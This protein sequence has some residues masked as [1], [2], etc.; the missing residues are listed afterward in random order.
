MYDPSNGGEK[1]AACPPLV[2]EKSNASLESSD[3]RRL[4][5]FDVAS[6]ISCATSTES[7]KNAC[8]AATEAFGCDYYLFGGYYPIVESIVVSSSF[9]YE[10]RAKYNAGGYIAIDPTVKHC[11][12]NTSPIIWQNIEYPEG[13]AGE[14]ERVLM[15]E[16]FEF[17][18]RSGISIPMHGSGAEGCMLSLVSRKENADFEYHDHAGL[19]VIAHAM[20]EATKRI[21]AKAGASPTAESLTPRE[22]ECLSW[23]AKG[24]T[25]WATSRILDV[26]ENTVIFHLRNAIKKL[27][28]TNRSHAVAKAAAHSK[29]T[30][31]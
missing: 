17:G 5:Y 4:L 29:I 9:P 24:K 23:T 7:L 19:Q 13:K 30:P 20:H 3:A 10:W 16:A 6:D 28:V 21:I 27:E 8:N 25:S 31:F 15:G 26:S 1:K 12:A 11:W 2:A 22:I 18:L 14:L